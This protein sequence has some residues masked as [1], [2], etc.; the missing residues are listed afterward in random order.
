MND[1]DAGG[2]FNF[3]H[4]K[5]VQFTNITMENC[6]SPNSIIKI[7]RGDILVIKDSRFF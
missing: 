7:M 6:N 5:N 2:I 3:I 1:N 4:Y